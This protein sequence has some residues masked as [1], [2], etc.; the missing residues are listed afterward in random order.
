MLVPTA[1]I[2][3]ELVRRPDDVVLA[4]V[5]PALVRPLLAGALTAAVTV[6]VVHISGSE[7]VVQL[8]VG[9]CVGLGVYVVTAVPLKQLRQW[10]AT[11]RPGRTPAPA[12]TD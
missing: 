8:I 5:G 11:I 6:L 10:A 4:S 7:P 12:V 9:G 2:D 3:T 1:C